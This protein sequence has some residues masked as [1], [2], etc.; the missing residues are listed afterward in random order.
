MQTRMLV[1]AT[2]VLTQLVYDHALRIRM[3]AETSESPSG[4]RVSTAVTTPD[5]ASIAEHEPEQTSSSS[6]VDETSAST[7]AASVATQSAKGKQKS[8]TISE[9]DKKAGEV[10]KDGKANNLIGK[11]NNLVTS[12]V[13]NITSGRDMFIPRMFT[14][15]SQS[16]CHYSSASSC[17][18][19]YR[20]YPSCY[21]PLRHSWLEVR[22]YS[23]LSLR[24]DNAF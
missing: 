1:D 12:D 22:P 20:V 7:T 18:Y 17:Y 14:H 8:Q 24:S 19:S 21:I 9:A 10:E 3:K 5:N 16:S 4:S 6:S 23:T 15:A 2:A 13:N 11:I